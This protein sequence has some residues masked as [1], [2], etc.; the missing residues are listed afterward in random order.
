MNQ[1]KLTAIHHVAFATA[2]MDET[3]SY[4]RDILG[5]KLVLGFQNEE[6]RQ[7]AF[8]ISSQMLI[9][10]FEWQDV[11]R[12]KNKRHG[13]PVSGPFIFDHL[14]ICLESLSDLHMLQDRLVNEDLPVSDIIDH[15]YINSIY[16]YDPNGIPLEFNIL[17]PGFDLVADPVFVDNKPSRKAREGL[18]T[19]STKKVEI[20]NDGEIRPVVQAFDRK[21]FRK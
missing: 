1:P 8:A 7:Y 13:E 4:W 18:V 17:L 5:L 21:F 11:T 14:A 6:G 19:P 9:Y 20:E 10:F 3:I 16:T 12:V 15:G 2:D